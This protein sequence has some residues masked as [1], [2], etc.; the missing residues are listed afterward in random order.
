VLPTES[1]PTYE[2]SDP[3]NGLIANWTSYDP[4][5]IVTTPP[6]NGFP[7]L[8]MTAG[9]A[10]YYPNGVVWV[11]GNVP[12]VS[13]GYPLIINF[14]Y[15][16]SIFYN[17]TQ[18]YGELLQVVATTDINGNYSVP[19]II[20]SDAQPNQTVNIFATASNTLGNSNAAIT[21]PILLAPL[22]NP[23]L[24]LISSNGTTWTIPGSFNISSSGSPSAPITCSGYVGS[25]AANSVVA[26]N[27]IYQ[28]QE[29]SQNVYWG[30]FPINQATGAFTST[31]IIVPQDI[32]NVEY[33][34]SS[35]ALYESLLVFE[36]SVTNA[37]GTFTAYASIGVN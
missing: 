5:V 18:Q 37:V 25:I 30:S 27:M 9:T 3:A 7:E 8:T 15:N 34:V 4:G 31:G 19:I 11:S 23:A 35:S 2:L 21:I 1:L 6:D 36:V 16:Q 10:P 28:S 20:P 32:A 14:L 17:S 29:G 26:V 13:I 24:P 12:N 22:P 33:L